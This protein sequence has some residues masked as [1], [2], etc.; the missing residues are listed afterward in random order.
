MTLER[1]GIVVLLRWLWHDLLF[2]ERTV[3]ALTYLHSTAIFI[4]QYTIKKQYPR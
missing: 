2:D 1:Y 3:G 4:P